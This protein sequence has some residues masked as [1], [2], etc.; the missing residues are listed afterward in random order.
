MSHRFCQIALSCSLLHLPLLSWWVISNRKYKLVFCITCLINFVRQV[1]MNLPSPCKIMGILKPSANTWIEFLHSGLTVSTATWTIHA[2]STYAPRTTGPIGQTITGQ[3]GQ[4][5]A[6]INNLDDVPRP[7]RSAMAPNQSEK[8]GVAE[9]HD[10][11]RMVCPKIER[12]YIF[13]YGS[14]IWR[15][16][17]EYSRSWSGYIKGYKRRFYQGTT[18]HRGTPQQVSAL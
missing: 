9:R 11:P 16:T 17:I 8:Q 7:L 13:G 1:I 12:L 14:L 4:A 18:T 3:W 6:Y 5:S 2:Q 10:I 15:P